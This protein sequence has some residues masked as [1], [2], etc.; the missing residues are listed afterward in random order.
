MSIEINE[1]LVLSQKPRKKIVKIIINLDKVFNKKNVSMMV[2]YNTIAEDDTV[3]KTD[4]IVISDGEWNEFW[5]NWEGDTA[6]SQVY[7]KIIEKQKLPVVL[8]DDKKVVIEQE[9]INPIKE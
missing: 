9:I 4:R 5:E 1:P 7:E 8:T 6:F 3:L 2:I